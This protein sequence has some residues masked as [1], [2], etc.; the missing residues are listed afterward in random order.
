M[1]GKLIGEGNQPLICTPLIGKDQDA[2]L[3]ELENVLGKNPDIIEWRADFYERIVDTHEVVATANQIKEIAGTI[4]VI[5]TIRSIHEGGQPTPLSIN[6]AV[7][8]MGAICCNTNVEYVD[9]ELSNLPANIK[10]LRRIASENNTK[11]IASFHD[12]NQTPN[13]EILLQKFMDATKQGADVAKLAVMSKTLSDVL[14]LLKVTLDAKNM[15][16]IPIITISMGEYGALTRLIGGVFGSAVTF[17]VGQNSSAPGQLPIEDLRLAL[18]IVQK[19]L[20]D[21]RSSFT[22]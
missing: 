10:K 14:T 15:L 2:I 3:L 16:D 18:S 4:P 22:P 12:F 20:G 7:D 11:I 9:C 17:A 1:N 21:Q 6:E 8:L 13:Q 5:F 19:S